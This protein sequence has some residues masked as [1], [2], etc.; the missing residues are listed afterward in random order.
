LF[1]S[2]RHFLCP[3]PWR[4][5]LLWFSFSYIQIRCTS[6]ALRISRS[7]T[8]D[9]QAPS[10]GSFGLSAPVCLRSGLLTCPDL[11]PRV[12][13]THSPPSVALR[14]QSRRTPV[15]S[16][17]RPIAK[18]LISSAILLPFSPAKKLFLA[19]DVRD[20][21]PPPSGQIP[22][23]SFLRSISS[24][25]FGTGVLLSFSPPACSTGV[26]SLLS[27]DGFLKF[28]RLFRA[29]A[30][31]FFALIEGLVTGSFTFFSA[32]LFDSTQQRRHITRAPLSH[33]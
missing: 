10:W 14:K 19:R 23:R 7:D 21:T 18:R 20:L 32:L 8:S 3:P 31:I 28:A 17:F 30:L 4:S 22:P 26:C 25:C 29:S 12:F 11:S 16:F 33:S 24:F 2:S 27:A 13:P 1:E 6:E 5:H 15:R 9:A